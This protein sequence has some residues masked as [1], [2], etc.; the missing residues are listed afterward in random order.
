MKKPCTLAPSGWKCCRAAG[1][2]GPCAALSTADKPPV[3]ATTATGE[4]VLDMIKRHMAEDRWTL[5][6]PD[7]RSWDAENVQHLIKILAANMVDHP[8]VRDVRHLNLSPWAR[9]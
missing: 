4:P 8:A 5:I 6:A 1:H 9:G 3:E 2:E 7:G